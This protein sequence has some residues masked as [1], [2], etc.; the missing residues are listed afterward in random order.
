[1]RK[2]SSDM[3]AT[4]RAAIAQACLDAVAQRIVVTHGT[5]TMLETAAVVAAAVQGTHKVVVLTGAFLPER[6]KD[7][8]ADFNIGLAMGAAL[9]ASPGVYIAM[10]GLV[11]PYNCVG[12]DAAGNFTPPAVAS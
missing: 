5:S 11:L 6:F 10:S 4:D 9:A 2:D 12:R 8:D 1:M 7:S 3:D